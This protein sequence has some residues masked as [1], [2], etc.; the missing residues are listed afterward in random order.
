MRRI[1]DPVADGDGARVLVDRLWPRGLAKGDAPFDTWL[2]EAAPSTGL[3]KWYGHDPERHAEFVR[4]YRAELAAPAAAEA[5]DWLRELAAS[6]PLTLLTSAKDVPHSHVP[7][8][9]EELGGA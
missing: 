7:V 6:G 9:A 5:L 3:R 4:R 2:K 1:Y 8:I